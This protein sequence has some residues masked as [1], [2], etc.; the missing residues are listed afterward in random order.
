MKNI[1]KMFSVMLVAGA[2]MV[3]CTDPNTNVTP[4]YKITVKANNDSYGT[5][6]GGGTY[7]SNTTATLTATANE[8]YKFV[9]WNDGITNNPRIITVTEDATYTANFEEISGVNVTFGTTSWTAQYVNG[10]C[11]D[12]AVNIAAGQTSAN[13]YPIMNLYYD[14]GQS[15]PAAGTF[16]GAP[17]FEMVGETQVSIRFG[18]PY[19]WYYENGSFDLAHSDGTPLYTG[20]WWGKNVT[21]NVTALDADAM[22]ISAVVNATM[23]HVAEMVNEQGQLITIDLNDVTARDLTANIVN[24][25]LTAAKGLNM[26]TKVIVKMK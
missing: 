22:T 6:S 12:N 18:N 14:W 15:S 7:D 11:G 10:T 26:P 25:S 16:N 24:Q 20:D 9:N 2:V 17:A 23:A 8:G 21:L 19:L 3:G 1:F 4:K 5:V 13:S